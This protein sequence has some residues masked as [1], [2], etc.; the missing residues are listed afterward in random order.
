MLVSN[1]DSGK[2]D[3]F[4]LPKTSKVVTGSTHLGKRSFEEPT[5]EKPPSAKESKH[6]HKVG[7]LR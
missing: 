3:K 4:K 6:I 7:R 5:G 2:G 1:T